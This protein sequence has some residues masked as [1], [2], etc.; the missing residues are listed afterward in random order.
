MTRKGRLQSA[1]ATRWVEQYRGKNIV[2]GYRNWFGVDLACAVIEL[3]MLGV[4]VSAARAE[5]IA[6]TL[7]ARA[8]ARQRRQRIAAEAPCD[9]EPDSDATFPYIAGRTPRGAPYGVTREELRE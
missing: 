4:K 7:R 3:R 9:L 2:R 6:A 8:A 1:R 5:E